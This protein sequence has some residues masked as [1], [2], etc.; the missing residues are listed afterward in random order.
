MKL[1]YN[2]FM[3]VLCCLSIILFTSE[4]LLGQPGTTCTNP[5]VVS[6]LPYTLS[7]NTSDYGDNYEANDVPTFD[8]IQY[9]DGTG[10][11]SYLN[12][13][14]VVFSY[15]PSSNTVIS[16]EVTGNG[17][18]VGLWMFTGCPF[19][20]TVAYHTTTTSDP[21]LLP[22]ISVTTGVQYFIVISTWPAPQSTPFILNITEITCPNPTNAVL[23]GSTGNSIDIGW[24]PGA[25]ESSWNIEWGATG[26]TPGTETEIGGMSTVNS[27]A[28]IPGLTPSTPYDVYIQADCGIDGLSVWAGPF[29]FGIPPSNNNC[30]SAITLTP[31]SSP[32]CTNSVS[33]TTLLAS[34]SMETEPTCSSGGLG[35]GDVWYQ[36]TATAEGHTITFSNVSSVLGGTSTMA[37]AVY[38]GTC[39]GLVEVA[40]SCGTSNTTRNI[41]NLVPGQTYFVRVWTVNST[42]G[43]ANSFD[44]CI[45]TLPPPP[46]NN[47]CT[48]ATIL[49]VSSGETCSGVTSGSTQDAL[50]SGEEGPSCSASGLNGGDVWYQFTAT[51]SAHTIILSNVTNVSGSSSGMVTAVYENTCGN[52]TQI[53]GSCLSS[54]TVLERN[55]SGLTAGQTYYV[56]V[57]TSSSLTTQANSFDICIATPPPPP[58]NDNCSSATTLPVSPEEECSEV[59]AGTTLSASNSGEAEPSCSASGLNGG[60]VWYQFTA[61]QS[62]HTIILS[63]I[64]NVLGSTSGMVTAVYENTCG[65]LTEIDGSCVSSSTVLERIISGLTADQT[66]Y[67]RVWTINSTA[68]Q[69]NSFDICIATP[70]PPPVNDNC[71]SATTLTVSAGEICDQVTSGTTQSASNSGEAAPSCTSAGLAGGD[72]WYQFTAT[73]SVHTIVLS[74]VTNISGTTSGMV[75]AVYE[76]TC[77]NLT[78]VDGSCLSSTT[79]LER[80]ISGLTEGQT[81]YVR[82]WTATSTAT[83]ANSFDICI[84]TPPPP[85]PND[86]CGT[87]QVLSVSPSGMCSA[88][89]SG[90]TLSSS[91]SEETTPSCATTGLNGGDVWYQ[92][93]A[94]QSIHVI[95]FSNVNNVLGG[96]SNMVTAVYSG[97]CGSLVQL[98][99]S[100]STSVANTRTLT[101]LVVDQTYYIRVWTSNTTASQ[102]NEF[103]ICITSPGIGSNCGEPIVVNTLPYL[104]SDNTMF[105]GSTVAGSPGSDCGTTSNYLNGDDVFYEYTAS[106]DMYITITLT[107]AGTWSGLFV[108]GSCADVGVSCLAGVANSGTDVREITEFFMS[109]GQTIF[110]V[111]STFAAPQNIEYTL[112]INPVTCPQ[113]GAPDI[114]N[115]TSS[116]G[117]A[118]WT[119]GFAETAWTIEWG[120]SGFAPGTGAETGSATVSSPAYLITGLSPSTTY[121]VYVRA[122]CGSSDLSVWV[123]PVSLSTKCAAD[124]FTAPD[125]TTCSPGESVTLEASS[126]TPGTAFIW[127]SDPI[128][129]NVLGTGTTFSTPPI[130]ENTTFYVSASN[131]F[132]QE[133]A[134]KPTYVSTANTNGNNWGLVFDVV[135]TT[136]V[137]ESVDIYSVASA[138]GTITVELHDNTGTLITSAGPFTFPPGST[139]EPTLV[140]LP[141]NITVPV[142]SGYR[143]VSAAMSGNLIRETSGNDYPYTSPSGNVS[144]VSGFITNP[145][146]S[147]YYWF[148]NWQVSS[149]CLSAPQAVEVTLQTGPCTLTGGGEGIWNEDCECVPAFDCPDLQADNGDPCD[150]DGAAGILI[151]CECAVFDCNE[152]AGGTAEVD[153]CGVCLVDG[154]D[155]PDWNTSC[156]DCAGVPN[157]TSEVDDCGVCLL[158]G[159]L[160][161]D[162]N[163]SCADC[164]GVPNGTSE[165]DDCGVCLLDGDLNPD[166]N[167]SCADCAGVPNGT[168]E[169]DDCG[170][171]LLDGDLNPDWNTS[172]A[173]CA[174]VPNGT[175]EVDDCGVCLLDGDQNP[176]WNT[177]CADCAGVPNGTS[178]VDDCGVC[179]LDGDLNPDWNTSCSDCAGVPNGPGAID[180]C[181]VCVAGGSSDPLWNASCT[182]CA[183][184]VNG[185]AFLDNC[186][187]CVGGTTGLDPC[188]ADCFGVLGGEGIF[189]ECGV[190]RLPGDP[191]FNSTCTDCEGVV[192]GTAFVDECEDCVGGTTGEVACEADC[193]GV[194]GGT[195]F[196]D[197]CGD[198]V[199]GTTGEVACVQDCA[200][201]FGGTAFIDECGDC[202]GGTTGQVACVADCAGIFGGTAFIDNCGDCVGGTTGMDPCV[203]DCLGVPGG[204]A[205]VDACGDCWANGSANP[206]WNSACTDCAGVVNGLAIID[207][208]GDCVGGTTGMDP[209]VADCLG[210]PGGNAEVDACGDC[211]ANGSANPNWNSACTDCAGVVNGFAFIDNCGDCVGGTTGQNACVADCLGVPGGSAE[212]DACGDCWANGSANPNWN[213][214]C[215]DCAG[216]VNG[217]SQID[218]CGDCILN[219]PSN[220]LWGAACAGEDFNLSGTITSVN[221]NPIP[222]AT[223]SLVGYTANTNAAGIYSMEVMEGTSGMLTAMKDVNPRNGI[224]TFDLVL[225]QR[226]ILGAEYFTSPYQKVAADANK[227]NMLEVGDILMIQQ[228]L[229]YNVNDFLDPFTGAKVNTSWRMVKP[230]LTDPNPNSA[231]VPPVENGYVISNL[232]GSMTGLDFIAV[233]IGDVNMSANPNNMEPG[234]FNSSVNVRS[235]WFWATDDVFVQKGQ[236]YEIQIAGMNDEAFNGF[237]AALHTQ[238]LEIIRIEGN[239]LNG[240]NANNHN[241]LHTDL[242]LI[243]WFNSGA[244]QQRGEVLFTITVEATASGKLSEMISLEHELLATEAY[245]FDHSHAPVQLVFNEMQ[246]ESATRLSGSYPNPF[247]VE[248]TIGYYTDADQT[249]EISIYDMHGKLVHFDVINST[250][251]YNEWTW[252][253]TAAVHAGFFIFKLQNDTAILQGKLIFID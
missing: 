8:N 209:C 111:V 187:D 53:D 174:G 250:A 3:S 238:G 190:C 202:V 50:N 12:G 2:Y 132:V 207:A 117:Y 52:L 56:R 180:D 71:S 87:A 145:G 101:D 237:Q 86:F 81:Y 163:T 178:E 104:T 122:N 224:S 253:P 141:L 179:L 152:V 116:T 183:G 44:I 66:Y 199:G 22:E 240:W 243:S 38:Q 18:W 68:N 17:T 232:T 230:G 126:N 196:L 206:S 219:G 36:F 249:F 31:D 172:C 205:E 221:G 124:P 212:I 151:E 247:K 235:P 84:A 198:C 60:D 160:N 67:V 65:N 231:I 47:T 139:A 37:T 82:V 11:S 144:V 40:G 246:N 210:V 73:Q 61:T 15:T 28:T 241:I 176:D 130:T 146:S 251:G 55:I 217:T 63:N 213:L 138:G 133:S 109:A 118:T 75:T 74:N 175:S 26:F 94:T 155:N 113:P 220:P 6:S 149:G 105:Y 158:D 115:V 45:G 1:R 226:H 156:A 188:Q 157:G 215:T 140:T 90:T 97:S 168:S 223:A 185:T 148:Y 181:D 154:S 197:D 171:C 83:Q 21:R 42:S 79:V 34:N 222:A 218:P 239:N 136:I 43:Q 33:G 120:S 106:A 165:V 62:V 32:A 137:L 201:V 245:A 59:T 54:T 216:V 4:S 88:S 189:D 29:I 41:G 46:L 159:D 76:N 186:G 211:W 150:V 135:N 64:S 143:L 25:T 7:G 128:G 114:S 225:I 110:I 214:A 170:V 39:G 173:D 177:S 191:D 228:L 48:N 92:F 164:A 234:N 107:P 70:P 125:L 236:T 27:F 119:P 129:Q 69:A 123:G 233:K 13:D 14:D 30:S 98:T 112:E 204:N 131:G 161:P 96:T 121:Q 227:N 85:P 153:E 182:D 193:A 194:F 93:V 58:A 127:T 80:V 23:T 162:W 208:C 203:A 99:G 51:Q 78:Q 169:V 242:A 10:S 102:A 229:I 49:S 19:S 9:A 142:G 89:V 72:V 248:T 167:T 108:Y 95:Q 24:T 147:T 134:G 252:K 77:G 57:W 16:V 100:C 192:N 5:I 200:G 91:N 244:A 20:S 195:A 166:W 103:D 184:V 35:G